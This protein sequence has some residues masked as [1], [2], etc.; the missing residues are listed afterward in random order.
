M[1][2]GQVELI[3]V[4]AQAGWLKPRFEG[5]VP[6]DG[7]LQ[8]KRSARKI[9]RDRIGAAHDRSMLSECSPGE[10]GNVGSTPDGRLRV[11][12]LSRYLVDLD[13]L[14]REYR[15][16][17]LLPVSGRIPLPIQLLTHRLEELFEHPELLVRTAP[18]LAEQQPLGDGLDHGVG[19]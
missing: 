7:V 1:G 19:A 12:Q 14:L 11:A 16:G 3:L 5:L 9:D 4:C 10:V 17:A 6:T 18:L 15:P 13:E 8:S 2:S